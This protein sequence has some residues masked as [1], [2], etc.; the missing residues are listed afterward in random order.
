MR[1]LIALPFL[2][3]LVISGG[4]PLAAALWAPAVTALPLT[5]II[6]LVARKPPMTALFLVNLALVVVV[7]VIGATSH[8][9]DQDD[10]DWQG[11]TSVG[12]PEAGSGPA[13]ER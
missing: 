10:L 5:L 1:K 3:P 9:P 12:S 13:H 6:S 2:V 11:R 4:P 8:L 7:G